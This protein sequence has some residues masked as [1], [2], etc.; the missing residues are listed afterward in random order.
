M[1]IGE[2]EV[3]HHL[4]EP[5]DLRRR[6]AQRLAHLARGAAAAIGDDVGGH[7]RAEPAVLLVDV[8]NDALAA[9]AARQ[10]EIDVGPF[11][12]LFREEA[13]EQQ[14]HL[15]RIDGGDAEAVADGA[16]GGRAAALHEDVLLPAVVHDVPDDQEVA[17]EIEL[18]DQIELARDLR[19]RLVVIRPSDRARRPR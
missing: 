3:V 7:R 8:L 2:L 17:G 11:A 12:A 18:L 14:L 13:L 16:V 1:R 15:D 4:G 9:V 6:R 5:V 10:I 19:A